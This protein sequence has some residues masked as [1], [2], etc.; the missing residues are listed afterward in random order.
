VE[1]DT[2]KA[3][4]AL[5]VD[6]TRLVRHVDRNVAASHAWLAGS[7]R[8]RGRDFLSARAREL[9]SRAQNRPRG[10]LFQKRI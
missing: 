9:R 7:R 3:R 10:A 2:P 4:G 8:H 1:N 6:E 5:Q